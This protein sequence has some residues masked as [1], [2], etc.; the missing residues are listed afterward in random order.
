MS[1]SDLKLRMSELTDD[2]LILIVSRNSH[3][4]TEIALQCARTELSRRGIVDSPNVV[5]DGSVP[6]G[7]LDTKLRGVGGWLLCMCITLVIINPIYNGFR[8]Y[9][10]ISFIRDWYTKVLHQ[11]VPLWLYA[12]FYIFIPI[13]LFGLYCGIQLWRISRNAISLTKVYL[14]TSLGF[15]ILLLVLGVLGNLI[16]DLEINLSP[17]WG[18][19]IFGTLSFCAWFGYLDRSK[20]VKNT[21][22]VCT[23]AVTVFVALSSS[24]FAQRLAPLS[25]QELYPPPVDFGSLPNRPSCPWPS[26]LIQSYLSRIS[27][28]SKKAN[29]DAVD[30]TIEQAKTESKGQQ[31]TPWHYMYKENLIWRMESLRSTSDLLTIYDLE[32]SNGNGF[33][34]SSL[35][36]IYTRIKQAL[37]FSNSHVGMYREV[38]DKNSYSKDT[39]FLAVANKA[40]EDEVAC[41]DLLRS[42]LKEL[43]IYLKTK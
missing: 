7:P 14:L 38:V 40:L 2:E 22:L 25:P 41:R 9:N 43:T 1:G 11:E 35:Q 16:F 26:T 20:R 32:C 30:L 24:A 15:G 31:P 5:S 13:L 28:L 17:L 42:M 23:L 19:L 33:N 21:Y 12:Q 36:T 29:E 18:Q 6:E 39:S 3:E 4:Y 27:D 8:I 37:Q 34:R 10:N